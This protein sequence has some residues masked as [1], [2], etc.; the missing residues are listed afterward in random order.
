MI[1]CGDVVSLNKN[2]L[3]TVEVYDLKAE[4]IPFEEFLVGVLSIDN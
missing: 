3:E 4:A 1:R 2:L